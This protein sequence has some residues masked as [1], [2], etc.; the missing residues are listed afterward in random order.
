MGV[1]L[2]LPCQ[3]SLNKF[4]GRGQNV[5]SDDDDNN[6]VLNQRSALRLIDGV[7]VRRGAADQAQREVAPTT[8][9]AAS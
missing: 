7:G 8:P 9:E 4:Q 3:P 6:A 1:W 5:A 2:N